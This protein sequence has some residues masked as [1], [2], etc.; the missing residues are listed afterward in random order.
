MAVNVTESPWQNIFDPLAETDTDGNAFTVTLVD[1]EVFE[2]ALLSVIFT[3]KLPLAFTFT[4]WVVAP[5]F[6][7]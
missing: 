1:E 5:L 6:H 7:K 4:L 2:Q 3:E